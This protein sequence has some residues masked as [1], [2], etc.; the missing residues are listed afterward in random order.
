MVLRPGKQIRDSNKY[1][2]IPGMSS[3]IEDTKTN[4]QRKKTKKAHTQKRTAKRNRTVTAT[5]HTAFS[6]S[7]AQ[8]ED[9]KQ[10]D[11]AILCFIVIGVPHH[12]IM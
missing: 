7:T 3:L 8:E 10:M 1:T 9:S 12:N 4:K 2:R 11:L 6:N 5:A